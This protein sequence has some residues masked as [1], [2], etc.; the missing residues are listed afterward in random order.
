AHDRAGSGL[1][2]ND[3]L[4]QLLSHEVTPCASTGSA[5]Y[6]YDGDGQRDLLRHADTEM[7]ER[8]RQT[9]KAKGRMAG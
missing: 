8:K 2:E 4:R 3:E 5:V 7:Y 1:P 6:P 9:A